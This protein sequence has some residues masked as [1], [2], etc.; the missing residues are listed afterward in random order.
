MEAV[1]NMFFDSLEVGI[2]SFTSPGKRLFVGYLFLAGVLAWWVFRRSGRKGSF[3]KFVFH[4]RVWMSVSAKLD[5]KLW[6]FN[7]FIKVALI[8]QYLV[9]G[10]YIAFQVDDFMTST[11]GESGLLLGPTATVILYTLALTVIGDFTV[12]IVHRLMHSVPSLWAFHSLHHS[13]TSLS[14]VTQLRLHPVELL[15]NNLRGI[16]VFGFLTGIFSYLSHH[17]VEKFTFVIET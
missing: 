4:P 15:M 5:Y 1:W 14:P 16:V 10:L 2:S 7:S 6:L 8:S 11:W 12:Y 3:T 17:Q 9:G 13:A